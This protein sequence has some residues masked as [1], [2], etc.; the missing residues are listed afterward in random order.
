MEDQKMQK[1]FFEQSGDTYTRVGNYQLSI[2]P[3][4][5][6]KTVVE[7]GILFLQ[8]REGVSYGKQECDPAF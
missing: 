3:E 5:V 7:Y 1:S 2:I 8:K 6:W 4:T